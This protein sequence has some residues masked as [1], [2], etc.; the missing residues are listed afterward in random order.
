MKNTLIFTVGSFGSKFLAY[1]LTLLYNSFISPEEMSLVEIIRDSGNA[2]I[3][4][5][6]FC[7]SEAILRF[8]LDKKEKKDE[9]FTAAVVITFCGMTLL[10]VLSPLFNLLD[11]FIEGHGFM[12]YV[13]IFTSCF[14]QNCQQAV[15]AKNQL[16][17]FALDGILATLTLLIFNLLF[18]AVFRMGTIGYFISLIL[19]DLCSILFLTYMAD[20]GRLL[21]LEKINFRLVKRM[22]AYS[23]PLVPSMI[24]WW[25]TSASDKF[26]V[27]G[28]LGDAANGVYSFAYRIPSLVAM[29]TT[30]FQQAWQISAIT[31]L[32]E[33]GVSRFYGRVYSIYQS[34]MFMAGAGIIMLCV[35]LT[36]ILAG[37]AFPEYKDAYV[38]IPILTIATVFSCFATFLSSIYAATKKSLNSMW[39][40]IAG[41]VT[42]IILNFLLIPK[43]GV[44]G[45]AIATLA[46]YLLC[47]LLRLAD[48]RKAVRFK[49][50]HVKAAANVAA[51]S[52]MSA[53]VIFGAKPLWLWLAAGFVLVTIL[54]L[55]EF[56]ATIRAFLR[57]GDLTKLV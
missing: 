43:I 19:S 26:F 13:F 45:A 33:N 20:L 38:Y 10:A 23:L 1:F 22:L 37:N 15:R 39:T 7:A 25:I 24:M 36:N 50:N 57:R 8:G 53:A 2:L 21:H 44:Q 47:Y 55:G 46:S 54:N 12:L 31:E 17:L 11:N 41:A 40:S 35:P 5:A 14:R 28:M 16:R 30:I 4:A 3:P 51:L 29:V 56:A 27:K 6:F 52:A 18:I 34:V 42:N 49:V 48:T 32:K 9:V